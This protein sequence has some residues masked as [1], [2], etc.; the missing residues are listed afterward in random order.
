MQA[1]QYFGSGAKQRR[2]VSKLIIAQLSTK[3]KPGH[4]LQKK[5]TNPNPLPIALIEAGF[6]FVP[7]GGEVGQLQYG[8]QYV[9]VG[10]HFPTR[11]QKEN[12]SPG[13]ISKLSICEADSQMLPALLFTIAMGIPSISVATVKA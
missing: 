6:G 11:C 7:S 10:E 4:V 1:V 9:Q 12:V 5:S 2:N 3:G 13:R 8:V